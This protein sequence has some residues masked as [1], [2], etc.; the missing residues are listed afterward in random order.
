MIFEHTQDRRMLADTLG[1]FISDRNAIEHRNRV[2]YGKPGFSTGLWDG[3][4]ELGTVGALFPE[5]VGGFGGAGFDISVVFEALGRGLVVEPLLGSLMVGQALMH[6]GGHAE[7]LAA[8]AGGEQRT[9]L[10]WEEAD[11][12]WD[13]A[14]VET[15]ATPQGD[16]WVLDGDKIVVRLASAA[17]SLLVSARTG[18]ASDEAAGITLFLV[19]AD[20][21]GLSL[22]TLG[23]ID[24]GAVSDVALR[25]VVVG[26]DA[27]VGA[28][29]AG[30][31]L[32][33]RALGAGLLG[34]CAESVGAMDIARD[35]TID[36]LRTRKQFNLPIGS[37]QALQHRMATVLIEIE[38][39]RSAV[40]NAA[41]AFDGEDRVARERALSAAK[42]SIGRIGA[43]VAEEC[44]QLHGGIGMT[45]ELPLS[46]YAKRL[47]AI[48]HQLG[49]ED[50]HL[51]RYI[52]L[53][54]T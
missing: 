53:A 39:A 7:T 24:G 1:R 21:P 42:M 44:I 19:P 37:F 41:A 2:A 54:R 33:E 26:K 20:A 46:H 9:A 51:E 25:Q 13:P 16:G 38:Q 45:W 28:V 40:I 32:L 29:G 8:I 11:A 18:G 35:A 23:S 47:V 30:F 50:Y 48:D 22:H 49:D 52:A 34:L 36:Y 10:A 27:V 3:L 14:F 6:A 4:A 43:L 31:A 5:S 12:R 17:A 15:R